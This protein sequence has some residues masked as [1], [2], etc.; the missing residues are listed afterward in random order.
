MFSTSIPAFDET[1]VVF[2]VRNSSRIISLNRPKKLN[3]LNHSMTSK[4]IPR[5]LEYGHSAAASTVIIDTK[6]PKAF[7]AGGDVVA[8]ATANAAGDFASTT[9]FFQNEYYL[10]YLLATFNKP[11]IAY[12]NGIT[13]GGGVGLSAHVPFRIA[14]EKTMFAMP[15]MD[16]GLFPD[17]GTTFFLP[18]MDGKLGYYLAMTGDRLNGFD[19]LAAGTATHYV[20]SAQLERLTQR[21]TQLEHNKATFNKPEEFF[22]VVNQAIEDFAEPI[23]AD[24]QF[25]YTNEQR[26]LIDRAF[27]QATFDDVLAYLIEDGS[28]FAQTTLQKLQTKSPL[29]LKVTFEM[30][31]KG[32]V[33]TIHKTLQRELQAGENFMMD[34]DF[35]EGV[36]AKLINKTTPHWKH[37][38][39]ADVT[40]AEVARFFTKPENSIVNKDSLPLYEN[41]DFDQYP[42]NMGLPTEIE[43]QKYINGSDGSGRKYLPTPKEVKTK[44]LNHYRNKAGV[45]WKV[46]N[47]LARKCVPSQENQEYVQWKL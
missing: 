13:M 36:T 32:A 11:I 41:R 29:S 8:C 28:E 1:D 43:I 34:S 45:A 33:S 37:A 44:F 46:D 20:P 15:E 7:C 18:R 42:Y 38:S 35:T 6:S 25:V 47:V 40:A 19:N 12:M 3:S 2:D 22:Q 10:N 23:P 9:G 26:D 30:L 17:V 21:L 5:L 24:Y 39:V 27:S 16:I 14:T 31:N 4:I